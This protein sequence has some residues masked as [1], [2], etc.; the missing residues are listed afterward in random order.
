MITG[1]TPNCIADVS[2]TILTFW[3]GLGTD[4]DSSW[5]TGAIDDGKGKGTVQRVQAHIV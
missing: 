1:T 2:V 5:G 3:D 4:K